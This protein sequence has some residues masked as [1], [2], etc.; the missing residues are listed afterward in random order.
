[1]VFEI[2]AYRLLIVSSL[3]V[4]FALGLFLLLFYSR[5]RAGGF[6]S[7]PAGNPKLARILSDVARAT[8]QERTRLAEGERV[9]PPSGFAIEKLSKPLQDAVRGRQMRINHNAEVQV[10]I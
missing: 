8:P 5:S 9:A 10:Y 4:F 7:D 1:M 2:R 3:G 6:E